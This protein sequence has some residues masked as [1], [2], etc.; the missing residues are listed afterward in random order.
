MKNRSIKKIGVSQKRV[1]SWAFSAFNISSQTTGCEIDPII[2]I[3]DFR[4]REPVFTP[5]PHAGFSAV[6][7]LFEDSEGEF[8]SRDSMGGHFVSK[9]GEVIW[10]IAG[11]G[12]IHDEYPKVVGEMSHG[13]QM[14]IN[15]PSVQKL[16]KPTVLFVNGSEIPEYNGGGVIVRVI[17]GN[18]KE[19]HAK[20]EPPGDITF[21]DIKFT[22]KSSFEKRFAS[23]QNVL[24]YVISGSVYVGDEQKELKE[25]QT[26]VLNSESG[27]VWL[28]ANEYAQVILLGSTPLHEPV[29][30]HGPFIMNTSKQI[31]EAILRYQSGEMGEL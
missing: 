18:M 9:P 21:L 4:M 8:V 5:H 30:S 31:E 28:T 22:S 11:S 10:N 19:V 29:V 15:L 1:E 27:N 20:I 13:L 2:S 12:L 17:A 25:M 7:Y 26:A 3:D 6:T 14:F 24:L 16:Q 23:D